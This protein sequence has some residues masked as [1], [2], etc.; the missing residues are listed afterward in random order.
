MNREK[1]AV[2]KRQWRVYQE[3]EEELFLIDELLHRLLERRVKAAGP[4]DV[5]GYLNRDKI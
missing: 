4:F 2:D 5:V 1:T 3:I